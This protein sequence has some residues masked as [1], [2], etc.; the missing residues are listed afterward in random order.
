MGQRKK[1]EGTEE[2]MLGHSMAVSKKLE[3]FK[4]IMAK[5]TIIGNQRK[6]NILEMYKIILFL[7][8]LV[9]TVW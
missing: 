4:K 5:D 2:K 1:Q 8:V 3:S 6:F 9:N 7:M